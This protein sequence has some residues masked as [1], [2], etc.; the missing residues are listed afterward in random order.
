MGLLSKAVVALTL[1]VGLLS[2]DAVAYCA[3][4]YF[5]IYAGGKTGNE[6]VRCFVYDPL[7]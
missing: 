3:E 1:I 7:T 6:D 2:P 5:P 4:S